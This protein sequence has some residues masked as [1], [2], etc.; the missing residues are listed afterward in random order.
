MWTSDNALVWGHRIGP[1]GYVG[2]SEGAM[3]AEQSFGWRVLGPRKV[4][5]RPPVEVRF[6]IV[7]RDPDEAYL[8]GSYSVLVSRLA[9]SIAVGRAI[10]WLDL[11][12]RNTTAITHEMR[13]VLLRSG[14]EVLLGV[15]D[16]VEPGREALANL[17]ASERGRRRMRSWETR[18][19]HQRNAIMSDLEWWFT[20][21]VLA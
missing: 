10:E 20:R 6:P 19:H 7:Q 16:K 17:L 14:F 1:N 11:A 18:K 12:W 8:D 15:G 4:E 5:I 3:V 2:F 9:P 21:F 13:I